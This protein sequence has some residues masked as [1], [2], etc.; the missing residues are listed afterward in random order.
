MAIKGYENIVIENKM[1]DLVNTKIDVNSLFT[2][3]YSL[4]EEAGLKK[5]INKY[6]KSS[7]TKLQQ[8]V[9]IEI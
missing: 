6:R 1:T 4:A 8:N 3:D 7:W 5:V 2:T 9:T